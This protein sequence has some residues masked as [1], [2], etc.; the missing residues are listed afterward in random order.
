MMQLSR[1]FAIA[2]S[3]LVFLFFV[4]LMMLG[5]RGPADQQTYRI[6]P[7]I[8]PENAFQNATRP[9]VSSSAGVVS[10]FSETERRKIYTEIWN[11]EGRA[12]I[13][14][15]S[16]FPKMDGNCTPPEC[17]FSTEYMLKWSDLLNLKT[18]QYRQQVLDK[19]KVPKE[20]E[21]ELIQEGAQKNWC[22][23]AVC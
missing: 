22:Q 13:E 10:H 3:V 16:A 6:T 21:S 9:T 8:V 4:A 20:L 14:A 19:Y 7:L 18:E 1:P 17:T 23:S 12:A 2:C 11:E 5:L 15:H